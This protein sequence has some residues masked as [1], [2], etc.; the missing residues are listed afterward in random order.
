MKKASLNLS[1]QAIVIIV[2]AMT[3]MGLGLG[4]VRGLFSDIGSLSESTFQ[5]ISEQL[6]TDLATSSAPL[7][8]SQTRLTVER[9]ASSLQGFGVRN[10][11]NAEIKYGFQITTFKCPHQKNNPPENCPDVSK[12][13]DYFDSPQAYTLKAAERQVNKVLISP[14][15][16]EAQTGLYLLKM[17]AYQ[18]AKDN[19]C[20]DTAGKVFTK[21]AK[22]I[23]I[24]ETELF[25]TVS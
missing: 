5:K 22:C 25:L 23:Q 16:A 21:S 10:E 18:G 20:W 14:V 2:L 11:G 6:S 17:T 13:F 19:N 8:F 1:I 12:W 7:L 15:S 24:G 9:G 3:I 4:F